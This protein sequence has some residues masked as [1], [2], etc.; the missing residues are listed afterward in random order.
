MINV[1]IR[2]CVLVGRHASMAIVGQTYYNQA[3][4]HRGAI[5]S[6]NDAE[7]E[8]CSGPVDLNQIMLA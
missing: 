8:L 7:I 4:P 5:H 2:D 3:E 6:L 1:T